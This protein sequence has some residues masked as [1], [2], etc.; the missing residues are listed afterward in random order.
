MLAD[1]SPAHSTHS[2]FD[3]PHSVSPK[4]MKCGSA[5]K[6]AQT[7]A[8]AS[9]SIPN[10]TEP[11]VAA[12]SAATG[13]ESG[14]RRTAGATGPVHEAATSFTSSAAAAGSPSAEHTPSVL[15]TAARKCSPS[16][17]RPRP[18]LAGTRPAAARPTSDS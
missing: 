17:V 7:G 9:S 11:A 10:G 16:G 13:S 12:G 1:I 5:V 2:R 6:S 14:S 18:G 8:S 3:F 15:G 4:T